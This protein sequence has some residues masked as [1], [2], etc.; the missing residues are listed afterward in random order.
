ML[1]I[2]KRYAQHFI[3]NSSDTLVSIKIACATF[4]MV[5]Q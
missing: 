1:V 2:L 4:L 3:M 5:L